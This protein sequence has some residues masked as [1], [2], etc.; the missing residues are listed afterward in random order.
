MA[1]YR[2][3]K[4]E[5]LL[6]R[7]IGL[8]IVNGKIKDPRVDTFLTV[9]NVRVSKDTAYAKVYISSFQNEKSLNKAV[10]ALNHAAGYIQALLNKHLTM[11]HTPKLSFFADTSIKEGF[12]MIR[13]I[14]D[15][16]S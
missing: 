15:L 9:S 4:V 16:E 10:G 7:E 14:E 3:K 6:Q 8:L 1:T 11:R 2:L 5:S 13:K 12:N